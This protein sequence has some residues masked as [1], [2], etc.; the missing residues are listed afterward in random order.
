MLYLIVILLPYCRHPPLEDL[1]DNVFIRDERM[2]RESAMYK[3]LT[4]NFTDPLEDIENEYAN[5]DIELVKKYLREDGE[6]LTDSED[7]NQLEI[8]QQE[9]KNEDNS[10][11]QEQERSYVPGIRKLSFGFPRKS[12]LDKAQQAMCLRVLL[13][14]SDNEKKSMSDE[15]RK[16][17]EQYMV[18]RH[19][20]F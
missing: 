3:I 1:I 19:Q 18:N 15:E 16:E 17:F 8:N 20:A 2:E 11:M 4:G 14:L 7:D 13:R 10:R 9:A 5:V 12:R 6:V